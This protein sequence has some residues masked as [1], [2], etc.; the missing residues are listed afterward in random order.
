VLGFVQLGGEFLQ[1][2]PQIALEFEHLP[3]R[4]SFLLS[5]RGIET[6]TTAQHRLFN[7]A[8]YDGADLSEIF[9]NC[10][11]L[12]RCPHEEFQIALKFAN[13][14]RGAG[15]IEAAA[16][17]M[18]DVHLVGLLPVSVHAAIALLHAVRVP[19]DFEV[20]Q[21]GAMVLQVYAFRSRIGSE[22]D[23]HCRFLGIGLKGCF[24]RFSLIVGHATVDHFKATVLGKA[25]PS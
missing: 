5:T 8:R 7:L 25:F 10:F 15:S 18:V 20:N 14:A 11:Y 12:Q 2:A 24:D 21:L 23:A 19:G 13:L 4:L 22:Q 3:R 16:N 6:Q 9:S 17:E 1:L